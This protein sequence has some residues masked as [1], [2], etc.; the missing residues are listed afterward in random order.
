MKH[1]LVL[2]AITLCGSASAAQ[3]PAA[4]L[5]NELQEKRAALKSVHQEFEVSQTFRYASGEQSSNYRL[6]LDMSHGQWREK[7][8]L[9]WDTR[10]RIFD[11]KNLYSFDQGDDEFIRTDLKPKDDAPDPGLY[12][13]REMDW[14]KAVEVERRPCGLSGKDQ[15]CVILDVP[16][17]TSI[18]LDPNGHGHSTTKGWSRIAVSIDTGLV[19]SGSCAETVQRD[20]SP[21][22]ARC[23]YLL[24]RAA[25]GGEPDA[26][27]FKLPDGMHEVKTFSKWSA[28]KIGKQFNGKPAPELALTDMQGKQFTLG[29]LK[30]KTV[31]VDF[32]TTWC[33]GCRADGPAL[34]KLYAKYGGQN[35]EILGIS[36]GEDRAVVEKFLREHRHSYPIL[37]TSENELP[38]LFQVGALPTY[39]VIDKDGT[40]SGVVD[41]DQ[42]FS[43]LRKM[44]K[45]AGMD[46]D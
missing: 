7:Q 44:L 17:V 28:E 5:W 13:S 29:S 38:H 1:L 46:E 45:K 11:G 43:E 42:G 36:V 10:I 32:W 18:E 30:G 24:K 12:S 22:N 23:T 4:Q 9:G 41:G 33:V 34:D 6:T 25:Y 27:L 14:K 21:Y 2:L 8:L 19:I 15:T 37:L 26:T 20:R 16:L 40:L 3:K 31:L 35:L 39:M